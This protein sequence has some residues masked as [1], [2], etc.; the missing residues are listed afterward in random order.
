MRPLVRLPNVTTGSFY[1][2]NRLIW[3][4]GASNGARARVWRKV[5]VQ[6]HTE[7]K[8]NKAIF[9]PCGHPP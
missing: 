5:Q 8:D 9:F 6:I 4:G 3:T 1:Y 7:V 2:Y